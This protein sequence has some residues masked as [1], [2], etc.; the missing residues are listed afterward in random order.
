MDSPIFLFVLNLTFS[1][2]ISYRQSVH[3]ISGLPGKYFSPARMFCSNLV[4][5]AAH[6]QLET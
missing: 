2:I 5:I 4:L 3:G 6:K 1:R